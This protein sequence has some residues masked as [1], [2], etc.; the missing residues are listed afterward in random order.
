MMTDLFSFFF[1]HFCHIQE[2]IRVALY[3]QKAALTF[4]DGAKLLHSHIML[5]FLYLIL[6]SSFMVFTI[7]IVFLMQLLIKLNTRYQKRQRKLVFLSV[8]MNWPP[9]PVGM[10]SKV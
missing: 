1:F 9:L 2:K 3:V 4:I 8:L 5:L 7:V 10:I 6:R